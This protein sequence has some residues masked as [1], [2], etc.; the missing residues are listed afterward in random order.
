MKKFLLSQ[1]PIYILIFAII[2]TIRL[3]LNPLGMDQYGYDYGFYSYAVQHTP[4]D[5]PAYF[6]GQVNDYG[7]HL[8]VI[9][10][11]LRLPQIPSLQILFLVFH[12]IAGILLFIYL[13]KYS[14]FSAVFGVFLF[15]FSIA[16]TQLFTMFLWK[17]AYGQTLLLIIFLLL[18]QKK[19]YWEF[20]PIALLFI[21][22]KTTTVITVLSLVP[23]YLFV[24]KTKYGFII[25]LLVLCGAGIIFL[26][27]QHQQISN[28]LESEVRNGIFL[29]V[30]DYIKHS[31]Y[32]IPFASYGIYRSLKEKTEITWLSILVI[33]VSFIISGTIFYQR[34]ILF[35]DLALI[36]F[37]AISISYLKIN[38][39]KKIVIVALASII[40]LFSL[41][42]FSKNITPQITKSEILE[43]KKF[44]EDHQGAFVLATNSQD[45]PWL[46]ANLGGNIRLGAPGLFEDQNSKVEWQEFWKQPKNKLFLNQFPQPLFLYQ[47]SYITIDEKW[48][49]ISKLTDNFYLYT[50]N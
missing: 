14:L 5:S 39:P 27:T 10:N 8:F 26:L 12:A 41:L 1:L 11:W 37:S 15:C 3:F 4:L 25:P 24:K 30:S 31:W 46:L 2:V 20:I 23:H 44:S 29:K 21:T 35:T 43:I 16:Q 9:L 49:C 19:F 33:S 42:V 18:Q 6:L 17:G 22:H 45:G 13:R 28:L 38:T 40:G 48:E 36:T 7:N 32:L 50:C 34:I 47:K